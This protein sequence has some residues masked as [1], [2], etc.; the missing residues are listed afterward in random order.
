MKDEL[1]SPPTGEEVIN[2]SLKA[3]GREAMEKG[4]VTQLHNSRIG[5]PFTVLLWSSMDG[6]D[7]VVA[8][9]PFGCSLSFNLTQ[10]GMD[11]LGIRQ[12][13]RKTASSIV[14]GNHNASWPSLLR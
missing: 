4:N 3:S 11:V 1:V 6:K 5:A 2:K 14:L 13:S 10:S 8:Y 9:N 12:S 7:C